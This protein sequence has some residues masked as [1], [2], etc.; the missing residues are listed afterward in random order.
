MKPL[1][2][3]DL[4]RAGIHP[5]KEPEAL[6]DLIQACETSSLHYFAIDIADV[7]NKAQLLERFAETL[8]FPDYFGRNWD[9]L[10]DVLCDREWF[11]N[12]GIVL[13]LKHTG[14][15][16][17]LAADDWLALCAT[18]EEAIDYWRCLNLPFWVFVDHI[19]CQ[20]D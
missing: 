19:R 17:K 7:L 8:K 16:E 2:L 12:S 15:F 13:H 14:S 9:A 18:L 10:Y 1:S 6:A 11:G 3:D 20:F 4:D 5:L